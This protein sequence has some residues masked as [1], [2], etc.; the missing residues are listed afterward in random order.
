MSVHL[1][2]VC[3]RKGVVAAVDSLGHFM[4]E[5]AESQSRRSWFGD[6]GASA[7]VVVAYGS[8]EGYAR[9]YWYVEFLGEGV[10]VAVVAEEIV[11]L[12]GMFLGR[13]P[14]HV[15]DDAEDGDVDALVAEH[16]YA[17]SCVGERDRKSTRLNSSHLA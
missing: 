9:E 7:V 2:F 17:L 5:M 15:V 3:R 16:G 11:F 1:H 6:D 10:D 14:R 8:H 13:E 4:G 12:V